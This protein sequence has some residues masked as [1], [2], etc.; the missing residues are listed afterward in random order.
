V[1]SALHHDGHKSGF[2]AAV[3][4]GFG[5]VFGYFPKTVFC[6]GVDLFTESD[7]YFSLDR[8]LAVVEGLAAGAL[9]YRYPIRRVDDLLCL[10][11]VQ[12][13]TA[14][15][16]PGV[17]IG[18]GPHQPTEQRHSDQPGNDHVTF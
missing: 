17:F 18:C 16:S 7:D 2:P 13:K 9:P 8:S 15:L 6:V 1:P 12:S 5:L 4:Q 14:V 10:G 11:D 3:K